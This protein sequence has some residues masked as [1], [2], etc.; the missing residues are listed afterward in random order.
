MT[1]ENQDHAGVTFPP[2]VMY[3]LCLLAGFLMDYFFPRPLL[4]NRMQYVAG[5]VLIAMGLAINLSGILQFR[6]FKTNVR[7]DKPSSALINGGPFRFTR[8]PLYLGLCLVYAGIAVASDSVWVLALLIPIVLITQF[9]IIPR[10]ER[11]ME[12]QFGG[13]YLEYKG[14]VRRWL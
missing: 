11:Y 14:R 6:K 12:R 8:N 2:P 3:L 4:P 7:P 9:A 5:A 1:G 10:E 13:E